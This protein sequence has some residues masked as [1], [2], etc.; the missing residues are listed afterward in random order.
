MAIDEVL[1]TKGEAL[2]FVRLIVVLS[3]S[4]QATFNAGF[5]RPFLVQ[6]NPDARF[7]KALALADAVGQDLAQNFAFH[8]R[9]FEVLEHDLDQLFQGHVGLIIINTGLIAGFILA[10]PLSGPIGLA[11]DLAFF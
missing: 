3:G 11:N 9:Q 5:D 4:S 7:P 6:P 1:F 2:L 8:I 10:L